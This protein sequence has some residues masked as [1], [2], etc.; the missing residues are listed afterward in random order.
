MAIAIAACILMAA[1]T[2]AAV[3]SW[4]QIGFQ[5]DWLF[6][7]L[8]SVHALVLH[9]LVAL[10]WWGPTTS[11]VKSL[12]FAAVFAISVLVISIVIRLFRLRLTLGLVVFYLILLLNIGGLYVAIN[13]Q[14]FRG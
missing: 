7:V 3:C 4:R 1:L 13:A 14:W 8:V 10:D 11:S 6:A 2:I 5:W 12:L 9:F